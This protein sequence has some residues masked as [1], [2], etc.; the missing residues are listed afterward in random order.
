M[1]FLGLFDVPRGIRT[2]GTH[3]LFAFIFR[4]LWQLD[5]HIK[6]E[7]WFTRHLQKT[8]SLIEAAD[9]RG[10]DG[11]KT[12]QSFK[13]RLTRL[14]HAFSKKVEN[15]FHALSLYF[16]YYNF[17]RIRKSLSITPAMAAGLTD[18]L[19]TIEDIVGLID[20]D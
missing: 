14:T 9:F 1:Q 3:F 15:H 8:G 7:F 13:G 10:E 11:N 17:V 16:M 20:K 12:I 18:R 4:W 2:P 6:A 19:W 5:G